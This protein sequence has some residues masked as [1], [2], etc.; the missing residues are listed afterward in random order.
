MLLKEKV[1]LWRDR[2]YGRQECFGYKKSFFSA[3]K[4]EP[5]SQYLP[6]RRDKYK[7]SES[8]KG[9][10]FSSPQEQFVPLGDNHI[11]NHIKGIMELLIYVLH[12]DGTVNFA[13]VDFDLRHTFEDVLKVKRALDSHNVHSAIARSTKKGHHIYIFFDKLIEAKYVTSYISYVYEGVGFGDLLR[14][15]GK[16]LPETFPK[17]IALKDINSTGYGIKPPMQGKGLEI[18]QNCWV[19]MENHPIG[20]NGLS[21]EQWEYFKNIPKNNVE[22]FIG[23]L[24]KNNVVIDDIRLSEKRGAVKQQDYKRLGPYE[25]PKDGDLALV[26]NG[27]PAMKRLW[28]GPTQEMS[29]EARVALLSWAIQTKN[30]VDMLRERWNY[31]QKAEEQIQYAIETNQKPWTCRGLQEH[32]I[33]VK[34]KDPKFSTQKQKDA[35]GNDLT[36]Y[37]FK[38]VPPKVAVNGKVV[39]NPDNLPEDE[40]ADPSPVRLRIPFVKEGVKSLKEQIDDLD[41]NDRDLGNKISSLFQNIV[42][43]RDASHRKD[44]LDHLKSKKLLKVSELKEFEK[45]A[46][47]VRRLEKERELNQGDAIRVINGTRYTILD[48]GGYA[49]IE[50]DKDGN[51]VVNEISN[52]EIELEKDIHLR[53]VLT[54]NIR[55]LKGFIVCQGK[56]HSFAIP[57]PD[58]NNNSKLASAIAQSAGADAAFR[59]I[60]LDKIREAVNQFGMRNLEKVDTYEDYGFDDDKEP[61]IYRSTTYN[62][63]ADGI[64]MDGD[65]VDMSR[66]DFAKYLCLDDITKDEFQKIIHF[67]KQE[68]LKF[69]DPVVIFPSIAHSLQ[70]AI[71]NPYIPFPEAPVLWIQGTTGAGKSTIAK[72]AQA[73]HGKFPQLLNVNSTIRGIEFNSMLFKDALLVIDDYKEEYHRIGTMK[74]L[75]AFYDRSARAKQKQDGSSAKGTACRGLVMFTGEDRPTSEASTLARC[76]YIEAPSML[77]EKDTDIF[78]QKF[79]S[80]FAK[81]LPGVT[82]RFIHYMLKNYPKPDELC[83]KFWEYAKV[84]RAPVYNRQNAPRISQNLA[85]N[86]MTWELFLEFL[87]SSGLLTKEEKSELREVHWKCMEEIRDS[88]IEFCSEEQASNVFL[89]GLKELIGSGKYAIHG[90][91]SQDNKNATILGF[92]GEPGSGRVYLFPTLAVTAVKNML[93]QVG[94]GLSHST[95][96]IGKQLVQDGFLERCDKGRSQT[97]KSFDGTMRWVWSLD[98]VKTGFGPSVKLVTNH[99]MASQDFSDSGIDMSTF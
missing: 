80:K 88:M 24:E 46:K 68:V 18:D 19:D 86:Y 3:D 34:G 58:W 66:Q 70:A 35:Y 67:L 54:G 23:L 37:C 20:G 65:H 75:Q 72:V 12:T 81:Y 11:E 42:E 84:L 95:S 26:I 7:T 41:P 74:V 64:V 91:G 83:D 28:E 61:G 79:S 98:S 43:L 47:E 15:E 2:F 6:M 21:N 25:R 90:L 50:L 44:V 36:D 57:T 14:N 13:A 89:N 55:E 78:I 97:R 4:G 52:F 39:L 71:H 93:K 33:C 62:V 32:G 5:V 30:G 1:Q 27:C 76:I 53:S 45:E 17:T 40:W 49:T 69:Q 73:F 85:A 92:M 51:T 10:V 99:D 59:S 38:K 96:A 94:S 48:S 9:V 16:A 8:R 77:S 82:A 87:D 60:N 63:T 22:T 29:H 56:R 31:S